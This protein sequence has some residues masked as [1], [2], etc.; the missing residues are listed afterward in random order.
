[1]QFAHGVY[2]DLAERGF[3]P[4]DDTAFATPRR[5]A[6]KITNVEDR[7]AE[8]QVTKKGPSV[9]AALNRAGEPT[10]ALIGF[11]KSCGVGIE[12]LKRMSDAKGEYFVFR[13]TRSG[14]PIDDHLAA[15][16]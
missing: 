3:S 6:V 8:Q 12:A 13:A 5:L 1:M 16:V 11:A 9:A 7:Q 10:Q 4:G 2:S 14:D 15:I